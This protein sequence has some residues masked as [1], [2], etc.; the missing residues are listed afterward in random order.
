VYLD[1][2]LVTGGTKVSQATRSHSLQPRIT[3][4]S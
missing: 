2:S 4:Y 3:S 1:M